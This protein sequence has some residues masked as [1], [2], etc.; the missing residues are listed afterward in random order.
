MHNLITQGIQAGKNHAQHFVRARLTHRF[1]NG[2]FFLS[3]LKFP[4]V[5]ILSAIVGIPERLKHILVIKQHPDRAG[6]L[7][8]DQLFQ[9]F[10]L[11]IQRYQLFQ[12]ITEQVA[13]SHLIRGRQI[14]A[15]GGVKGDPE[16][17]KFAVRIISALL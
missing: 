11:L 13:L 14:C 4:G 7:L 1:G 16:E 8:P 10:F 6:K 9:L 15:V 3:K 17:N 5:F 2:L 12:K